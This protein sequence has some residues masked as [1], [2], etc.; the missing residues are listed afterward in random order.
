MLSVASTDDEA[1]DATPI[2]ETLGDAD[3]RTIAARLD[4]PL[5]ASEV[6]EQCDVPLSTTYRKLDR[7][8]EV[9]LVAEGTRIDDGHHASVYRPAFDAVTIERAEEGLTAEIDAVAWRQEERLA[10]LWEE[11]RSET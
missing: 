5:T 1:A 7:L 10:T 4:E 3:C 8:T 2:C 6:S 9:G 11:V